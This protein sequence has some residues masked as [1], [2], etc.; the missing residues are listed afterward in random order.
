MDINTAIFYAKKALT[1]NETDQELAKQTPS[2]TAE[3]IYT[4]RQSIDNLKIIPFA[5][6]QEIS[7]LGLEFSKKEILSS[8]LRQKEFDLFKK[9]LQEAYHKFQAFQEQQFESEESH[10]DDKII[11]N[12]MNTQYQLLMDHE[13]ALL[14]RFVE[15]QGQIENI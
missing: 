4:M 15:Y 13:E 1:Q 2:L 14:D 7:Q 9:R 12:I 8:P 10:M 6:I 11:A 3:D 5:A